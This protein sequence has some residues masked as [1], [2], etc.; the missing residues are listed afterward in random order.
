MTKKNGAANTV[1]VKVRAGR[2]AEPQE[3]TY[4]IGSSLDELVAQFGEEVVASKAREKIIIN[5]Q[6]YLR[7]NLKNPSKD[8]PTDLQ[9]LADSWKPG[10]RAPGKSKVDKAQNLLAALSPEERAAILEQYS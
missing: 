6:D 9:S 8:G 5:L 3:V 10:V 4:S 7:N 1:S 2:D